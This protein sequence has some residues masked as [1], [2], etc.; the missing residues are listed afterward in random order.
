MAGM[1]YSH[2]FYL[3]PLFIFPRPMSHISATFGS[4]DDQEILDSLYILLVM[5][6]TRSWFAW[7]NSYFADLA[8]RKSSYSS[9]LESPN[10]YP[11]PM[12]QNDVGRR[13]WERRQISQWLLP[14][15]ENVV[16]P[17]HIHAS[18]SHCPLILDELSEA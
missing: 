1:R 18:N 9:I 15:G 16:A 12:N 13:L 6:Y 4:D 11:R 8:Q 10:N 2:L 3:F 14:K 5:A 7:A 17:V